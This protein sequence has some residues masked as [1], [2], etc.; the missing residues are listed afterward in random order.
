M[1]ARDN[2][3]VTVGF[4]PNLPRS[5]VRA[6]HTPLIRAV[7]TGFEQASRGNTAAVP[8]LYNVVLKG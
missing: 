5:R 7:Q 6:F 4:E 8:G 3:V 2:V 1:R